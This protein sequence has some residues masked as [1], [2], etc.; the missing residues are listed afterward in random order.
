[1]P[2][3]WVKNDRPPPLP[4]AARLLR[5]SLEGMRRAFAILCAVSAVWASE[6][7]I[8][9]L[10]LEAEAR[11]VRFD[12]RWSD[13]T[14]AGGRSGGDEFDRALAVGPGLRWGWGRPGQPHHLLAGAAALWL[15]ER[16]AGGGRQ[17][18]LLR[19]EAGYGYGA[20]DRWL[21]TLLPSVAAGR[22]DFRLPTAG[23]EIAL[24]GRMLEVGLRGGVRW[25]VHERWAL[26][27]ELGWLRGWDH[28]G[29]GARSLDLDRAGGWVGLSL[30]W[31][32][33]PGTR[34]LE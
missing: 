31:V 25:T 28:H 17:G 32:L 6:H 19:L 4:A 12:W 24:P 22:A 2:H 20:G 30:A 21:L 8:G 13:G 34:R 10:R 27:A 11:P 15:D 1:M 26:G 16:F 18:P 5:G 3:P 9:D 33:S 7:R 23:G 14:S 29:E